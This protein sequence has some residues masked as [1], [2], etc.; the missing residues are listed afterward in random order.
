MKIKAK[1][2]SDIVKVK[3]LAK[4]EM[5]T[6]DQAKKK[7][8]NS[9]DANFITRLTA[10]VNGKI[11]YEV[12]TSQFLSKNPIIKFQFK[13]AAKGDTL[14]MTWVDRKGNTKTDTTKIK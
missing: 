1:L 6:Y 5:T 14:E 7:S 9:D 3:A 8:G 12:S 2:K 4:H 13:G 11:V 10:S